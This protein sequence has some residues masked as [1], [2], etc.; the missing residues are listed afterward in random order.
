M[1]C[2]T[3]QTLVDAYTDGELDPN[4]AAEVREHIETCANCSTAY[5]RLFSLKRRIKE[6]A[7]YYQA[8]PQLAERIRISIQTP[9][10]TRI[11]GLS[12]NWRLFAAAACLVLA[13]SV[14]LNVWL[15]KTR[16]G[17]PDAVAEEAVASHIR[18]LLG[19]RLVDVPSSD[20]HTVKPWFNGKV[21]FSPAVKD[22]T[23][24]GFPLTGGRIDYVDDRPVASLVYQRRKH[25]IDL[26]VWPASKTARQSYPETTVNGYHVIRWASA[27]MTY[28]AVSDLNSNELRQFQRFFSE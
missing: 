17:A 7:T 28:C 23:S 21:P 19:S 24:A 14:G 5:D 15:L 18:A 8:S 27:G 22:L 20:Q 26:F 6:S 9:A 3:A 11:P 2:E 13:A 12:V 16:V 10:R 1:T 25:V 4:R